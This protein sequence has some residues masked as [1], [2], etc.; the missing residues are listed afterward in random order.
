M[1]NT[2]EVETI[3]GKTGSVFKLVLLAARRAQELSEG[4]N[5]LIEAPLNTKATV[6]AL[7]EIQEGM[8]SIKPSK[9]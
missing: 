3:K 6:V 9:K 2:I 8:I 5:R 4:A 7:R 1:S